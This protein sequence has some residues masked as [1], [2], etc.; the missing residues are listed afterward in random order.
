MELILPFPPSVNT[1]WRNFNGRMLI[2][3]KGRE[4]RKAVADQVVIQNGAKH[5]QGKVKMTIEA[6][7]P[8][9]RKRDLDNL[10]KAP[11]DA[12][13][14]AGVYVDDQLIV[15][16]RIFW[17]EDKGGKLKVKIEEIG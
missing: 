11:L 8:D 7:R 5:Y 17:A 1:Y 12:L 13:T 15:D 4:Y 3:K 14:H 2:S 6:W 10:L 9:E 16:L